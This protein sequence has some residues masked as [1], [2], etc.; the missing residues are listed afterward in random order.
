MTINPTETENDDNSI[1]SMQ[2]LKLLSDGESHKAAEVRECVS[3]HL[4]KYKISKGYNGTNSIYTMVMRKLRDMKYVY[5]DEDSY[6][7]RITEN[8]LNAYLSRVPGTSS[9]KAA[10]RRKRTCGVECP[11]YAWQ[12]DLLYLRVPSSVTEIRSGTFAGCSRLM[13]IILPDSVTIID[14]DVFEDCHPDLVIYCSDRSFA[15][16]FASEHS[17]ATGYPDE[18]PKITGG[19]EVRISSD[20][21]AEDEI[22]NQNSPS[23][24]DEE[25]MLAFPRM[26]RYSFDEFSKIPYYNGIFLLFEDGETFDYYDGRSVRKIE[27]VVYAGVNLQTK[28]LANLV[29]R[30]LHGSKNDTSVRRCIGGC[31]LLEQGR[32]YYYETWMSVIRDGYDNSGV[33]AFV[34]PELEEEIEEEVTDY[35]QNHM[36]F[37]CFPV[38]GERQERREFRLHLVATI[39]KYLRNEHPSPDWIGNNIDISEISESGMWNL[40]GRH[41]RTL[42]EGERKWLT[43]Q[44]KKQIV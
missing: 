33:E 41:F 27:R 3:L 9:S 30:N 32:D 7:Y 35:M 13:G 22:S 29:Y 44:I 23:F 34:E 21:D 5:F 14:D 42:T 25:L 17:I 10:G 39:R 12:K 15:S 6:G 43:M 18:A 36:T 24:S 37:A 28:R 19:N 16:R 38:N 20:D 11:N 26:K 1:S 31:M 2:I 4:S 40:N 8:G